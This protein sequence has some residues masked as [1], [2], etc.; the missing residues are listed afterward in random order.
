MTYIDYHDLMV[1]AEELLSGLAMKLKSSYVVKY[2][3]KEIDFTPPFKRIDIINELERCTGEQFSF[4]DFNCMD[5]YHFLNGLCVKNKIECENP[6][7]ISRLLDKL[8]GHFIEPQCIN[9]TFLI[10]HPLIMSPLSKHNRND[11]RLAERFELFVNG[12]EIS[13]AYTELNNHVVQEKA[14][15][16]QQKDKDQG[17]DEIP[18]PDEDYIEAMRYG[19]PPTGGCGIGIDRLVMFMT[20]NEYINEVIPFSC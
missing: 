9:P 2:L 10:N 5:F 13:N 18:V 20:N 8:I 19:L 6:K 1:M 3:D 17:D 15:R 16:V 7:T 4:E 14:F 11:G 12:I